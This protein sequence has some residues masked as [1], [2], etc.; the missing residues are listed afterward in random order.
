MKKYTFLLFIYQFGISVILGQNKY[1]K[2][3]YDNENYLYFKVAKIDTLIKKGNGHKEITYHDSTTKWETTVDYYITG[4]KCYELT[5]FEKKIQG[6]QLEWYPDGNLSRMSYYN[7]GVGRGLAYHEN[8]LPSEFFMGNDSLL[9]L[10]GQHIIWWDNGQV[11]FSQN[12]DSNNYFL[13]CYYRSGK[14]MKRMFIIGGDTK[15]GDYKEFY[16]NG[17]IKV[18]GIYKHY[19]LSEISSVSLNKSTRIGT[20][21][22]YN[23]KGK[24]FKKE[25]YDDSGKLINTTEY[26][27]G[28]FVESIISGGK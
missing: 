21:Y 19:A 7:S 20:W 24:L 13:N 3:P 10:V 6:L 2:I 16:E 27:K 23:E 9:A 22:F 12:L 4:F 17:K 14:L 18:S 1:S 28:T 11:Y 15:V 5:T 8:G 25:I 26:S